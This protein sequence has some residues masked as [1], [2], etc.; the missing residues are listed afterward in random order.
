MIAGAILAGI[1][2]FFKPA[3]YRAS[4][5]FVPQGTD[6]AKSGLA[7]LA[8]Q[9]GVSIPGNNG[10]LTPE[11]YGQLL[12]SREIL[13]V[14]VKD[15]FTVA[16]LDG[17]KMSFVEIF[18]VPGSSPARRQDRALELLREQLSLSV[19][20]TTGI[21][22]VSMATE[23][24]SVSLRIIQIAVEQTNAFNQRA[25]Q[26][27]AAAERRFVESRLVVA[28]TE[29]RAAEDRMLRF[30]QANRTYA[31]SSEL[32][33]EHDRLQRELTLQQQLFNSLTQSYEEVRIREFR[34]TPVISLVDQPN[35]PATPLARGRLMRLLLGIVV[36]GLLGMFFTIVFGLSTGSGEPTPEVLE[37]RRALTAVRRD[38][39]YP[40]RWLKPPVD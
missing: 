26:E 3:L 30:V 12:R 38:L 8:G 35:V 18:E 40:T 11:F 1:S 14:I 23:W 22:D 39:R 36:G 29:L 32:T 33:F 16:E 9:F 2:L 19:S 15:T 37:F 5:S 13:N 28:R 10:G 34:D 20:K 4:A 27:Q 6:A 21:I 17:K 31:A 24:P 25:R 7:S